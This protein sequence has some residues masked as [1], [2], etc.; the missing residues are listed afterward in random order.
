MCETINN[1]GSSKFFTLHSSLFTLAVVLMTACSHIDEADRLIYVKPASVERCVLLEDFTGQRCVNCPK[2][3]DEIKALQEQYG[4]ENVVAVGIHSGKL[5]FYTT[6]SYVGLST[7]E[8]DE[9]YNHW[10]FDYQPVGLIDRGGITN[11]TAWN[12]AVRSELQKTAP[13]KISLIANRDGN[14]LTVSAEV[15]GVD[16]NTTGKL[17]LWITEDNVAAFQMLPDGSV[18]YNYVHQHVFRTSVN[19]T[20]GEDITVAEGNTVATKNYTLAIPA[21]WKAED[22]SLI[23]FVYNDQGVQ[24]VKKININ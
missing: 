16:G 8:G 9:Y 2:A 7:A 24:Q 1:M 15:M 4:E 18:D 6:G 10:G 13:V 22:L 11:Y 20:W 12:T 14:Q 21:D 3:T 19:G 5:G 23:G 17:Q